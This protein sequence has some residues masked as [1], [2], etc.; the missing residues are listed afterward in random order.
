M[1]LPQALPST[2]EP[3]LVSTGPLSPPAEARWGLAQRIGF[4]F[5]FAYWVL[6]CLPFPLPQLPGMG[7]LTERYDALWEALV[8]WVGRHVLH[9]ETELVVLPTGSGDTTFNYVQVGV[10][11]VLAGVVALGW[12]VAGRRQ[13]AYPKL[14]AGLRVFLR[15]VL[16]SAMLSYGLAKVFKTQFPDP[17]LMRLMQPYGESSPMG[18]VWTFMGYST[19]YNLFTGGAEVLGA[20]LLCFRRTTTLG[21]LVVVGVM[22]N[23][24]AL[25]FFYDVPVKLLSSHLLLMA[26]FLLVPDLRRLVDFLVLNRATA[27]VVLRTPFAAPWMERASRGA[28]VLFLGWCLYSMTASQLEAREQWGAAAP[29]PAL[30]GIYQVESFAW[31]GQ[32]VPPLVTDAA[33]WRSVVFSEFNMAQLRMM[34]DTRKVYRVT[35]RPEEQAFTLSARDA[36]EVPMVFSYSRPDAQS[37]VLEGAFGDRTLRILLG[38]VDE[39]KL[40]LKSRGF[41]WINEVPFNR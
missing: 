39:S 27:P 15:Y 34:D 40:L 4:R 5:A 35:H 12:S 20:V 32:E 38:R 25:N 2:P 16:A 7:W 37:V 30:Y 28:K 19:G 13:A 9:L 33:R 31:D 14:H 17:S 1:S 41:H 11:A 24:A 18:L 6:Y 36:A 8:A 29:K 3:V 26:G 21:A 23:V 10:Y 22:S